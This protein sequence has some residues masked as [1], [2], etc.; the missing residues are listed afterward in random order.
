MNKYLF[1]FFGVTF[2]TAQEIRKGKDAPTAEES[3]SS[4]EAYKRQT[5]EEILKQ[6]SIMKQTSHALAVCQDHGDRGSEQHV[7]AERLLLISSEQTSPL[8]SLPSLRSEP[9]NEKDNL[10]IHNYSC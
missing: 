1:F 7:E 10:I 9:L 4:F 8:S 2:R 6:E 5:Q 3:L